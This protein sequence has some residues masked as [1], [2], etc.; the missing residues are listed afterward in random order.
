MDVDEPRHRRALIKAMLQRKQAARSQAWMRLFDEATDEHQAIIAAV[1]G[2]P[3][4]SAD[5]GRQPGDIAAGY[6]RQICDDRVEDLVGNRREQ[7]PLPP[8]E[9]ILATMPFGVGRGHRERVGRDV[10]FLSPHLVV[11]RRSRDLRYR[12]PCAKCMFR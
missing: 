11:F 3:R 12:H 9:A 8:R 7:V 5:V 1:Q 6:I 2:Q 4:F 10:N